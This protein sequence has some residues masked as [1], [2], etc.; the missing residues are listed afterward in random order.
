MFVGHNPVHT[1]SVTHPIHK[2]EKDS[3]Q[4]NKYI[5]V[6]SIWQIKDLCLSTHV[7]NK[8]KLSKNRAYFV[9]I[10]KGQWHEMIKIHVEWV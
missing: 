8:S 2:E 3:T 7:V 6:Y 4:Y 9:A 10:E 5:N 1:E